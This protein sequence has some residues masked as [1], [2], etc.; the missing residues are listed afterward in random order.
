MDWETILA[1][2]V[3][4]CETLHGDDLWPPIAANPQSSG[5][6]NSTNVQQKKMNKL[7]KQAVK[8]QLKEE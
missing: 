1:T 2:Q 4:A 3:A 5:T 6:A 8:T 7:I